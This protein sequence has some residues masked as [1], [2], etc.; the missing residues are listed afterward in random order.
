MKEFGLYMG[1]LVL[2][3]ALAA[4]YVLVINPLLCTPPGP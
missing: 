2:V 4:V 3:V 1:G